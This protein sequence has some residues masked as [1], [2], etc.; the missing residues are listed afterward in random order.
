MDHLLQTLLNLPDIRVLGSDYTA[1]GDLIIRVES[2]VD[3]TQ[4]RRCGRQISQF[5]GHDQPV[6]LRHLPIFE[7]RVYLEIRPRRYRCPHCQGNPTTTQRC[8]WY[9][10]NS[11]H[12]QAFEH[13]MLRALINSTV[14]DVSRKQ[15]LTPAAVEGI[16]ERHLAQAVDWN[17]LTD[18]DVIGIDEIAL[19]KGHRDFV[20]IITSRTEAGSLTLLAVLP[21]RSKETVAAFLTAIPERLKATITQVCTD[22]YTGFVNAA[23][24][25]LP[26][27][28]VVVDRFHVA[29]AYRDCADT[30]RKQE[31][32]RLKQTLSSADYDAQV[33]GTL[34]VFRK[35][36]TALTPSERQRLEQ[37]FE[38]APNLR[39]AHLMREVLTAIFDQAQSKAQATDW[40]HAW[41]AFVT[42]Q[43]IPGFEKFFTTLDNHLD[44]ITNYFLDRQTSGFVEGFNNKIKVLKR[45]CYG[46]FNLTHLFQRLHL[47]LNGYQLFGYT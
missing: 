16:I 18:L 35:P 37:V 29:N 36:W 22:M 8:A 1:P 21:D 24:E 13:D 25:S 44:E 43:A 10:T 32:K 47:D 4:C 19:R 39:T 41:R 27:A 6:R 2:T 20:T 46:L 33:K 3:S 12:T 7:R 17:R 15:A 5:H 40:L 11:P 45:R 31:V 28:V 34:W 26:E 38:L 42:L 30:V 23:H 14:V 9:E